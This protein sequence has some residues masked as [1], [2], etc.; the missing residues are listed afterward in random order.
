MTVFVLSAPR[1]FQFL[2]KFSSLAFASKAIII[3]R[4][5]HPCNHF[6]FQEN[7][8]A[9][10]TFALNVILNL[11]ITSRVYAKRDIRICFL[12]KMGT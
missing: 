7:I 12:E 10:L 4:Y 8:K 5:S 2:S 11:S 9:N 6:F 3:L 1:C